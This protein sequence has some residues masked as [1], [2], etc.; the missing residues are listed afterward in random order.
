MPV[1][2]F[3]ARAAD[4]IND[5]IGRAVSWLALFMVL[6]QFA[7]VVMRYVFGIGSIFMQESIVYMHAMVFLVASGYTLLHDGHVR[8]D[9]FY[10]DA[11]P[12]RRALVNLTGVMV[13]LIPFCT[14]ILWISWP[15]VAKAWRVLEVSQEGSGIPAVF[16][17]KTMILVFAALVL[18]QGV[19]L[20]IR[21][22]AMLMGVEGRPGRT[23]RGDGVVP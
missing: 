19:S 8:I 11:T 2:E 7:V 5:Q 16:L 1:L 9:I 4:A 17:L 3:L 13:F 20:G 18:V 23:D 6:I 14:L 21:S 12:R 22:L 10:G 15:Y